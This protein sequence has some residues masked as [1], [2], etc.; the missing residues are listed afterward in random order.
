M[1]PVCQS[2]R[3]AYDKL[4]AI[5]NKNENNTAAVEKLV[6]QVA[7][8]RPDI[9]ADLGSEAIKIEDEVI[10]PKFQGLLAGEVTPEEMYNAIC[11]AAYEVFGEEGCV[12]D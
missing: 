4:P 8:A 7:P 6:T 5:E 11:E 12:Q 9:P 3:D 2:G 10:V 1:K